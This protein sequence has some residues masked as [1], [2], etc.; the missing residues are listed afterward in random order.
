MN[1]RL[2]VRLE[3]HQDLSLRQPDW[4]PVLNKCIS[5]MNYYRIPEQLLQNSRAGLVVF[6]SYNVYGI[7]NGRPNMWSYSP[8]LLF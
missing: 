1:A 6:Y 7:E 3:S 2:I 8:S 4:E 5:N